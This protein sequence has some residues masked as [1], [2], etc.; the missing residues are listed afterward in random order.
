MN[1]NHQQG[2]IIEVTNVAKRFG[3]GPE[4]VYALQDVS[5]T[6]E[7]G[8]FI[9]LIGPSGCGK[10]TLLRII[11]D[12]IHL[13]SGDVRVKGKTAR[14][15]RA[16]R[17][18]GIVFQSPVLYEWRDPQRRVA[19][20]VMGYPKDEWDGRVTHAEPPFDLTANIPGSSPADAATVSTLAPWP[21]SPRSC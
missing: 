15:A 9:S 20:A 11:A 16:D 1:T 4:A 5:L 6:V 14:Q 18:Y 12:L 21:F 8:E 17:D 2:P 19:P 10:S 13:S 7:A 3:S